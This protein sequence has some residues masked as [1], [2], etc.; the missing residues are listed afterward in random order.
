M[1]NL[2]ISFRTNLFTRSVLPRH[3]KTLSELKHMLRLLA[4]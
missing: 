3:P 2:E 4:D 1:T